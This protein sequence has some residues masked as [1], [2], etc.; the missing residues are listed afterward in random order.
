MR[1]ATRAELIETVARHVPDPVVYYIHKK[2]EQREITCF[3]ARDKALHRRISDLL[4]ADFHA[5]INEHCY[6]YVRGRSVW[7][8][9]VRAV[10]Q[11]AFFDG[12]IKTDIRKFFPSIDAS[13][14]ADQLS[15]K[16]PLSFV[17]KTLSLVFLSNRGLATGSPLSPILSNIYMIGFDRRIDAEF[18]Y[19]RYSDDILILCPKQDINRIYDKLISELRRVKLTLNALKTQTGNVEEGIKF[20]GFY[21]TK[22]GPVVLP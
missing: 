13:L 19:F 9:V 7:D 10:Q 3:S 18:R 15:R 6:A 11:T 20:L 5:E 1:L 8:A 2:N 17:E 16:Y 4:W 12:F 14:L 22:K 21:V